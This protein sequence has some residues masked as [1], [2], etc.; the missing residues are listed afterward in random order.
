M[1]AWWWGRAVGCLLCLID[2]VNSDEWQHNTHKQQ[3]HVRI[4]GPKLL[5]EEVITQQN[6][7]RV[8]VENLLR[9][10]IPRKKQKR[11]QHINT[12]WCDVVL[13]AARH[14]R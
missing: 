5:L 3:H 11:T 8:L 2:L 9:G 12:V 6:D 14:R 7:L 4:L 10:K 1:L 13:A